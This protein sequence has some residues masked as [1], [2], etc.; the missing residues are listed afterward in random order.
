M[1]T[2]IGGTRRETKEQTDFVKKVG[3]FEAAVIAVNPTVEQFK[4]LLGRELPEDSKASDYLSESRDGN[5]ALRLSF[6]LKEVKT[7]ELF[8]VSFFLEDKERISKDGSKNQYINQTGVCSWAADDDGLATWFKGT[9]DNPKDY[10]IAY[11][12]EEQL[13][14][15][16]RTWLC[17]LDYSKSDTILSLDWKKLMR[18]NV[19]EISSQ[20]DGEWCG[21]VVAMATIATRER[22]GEMKEYQGVYNAAFLPSYAL[23]QFRLVNYNDSKRIS[24]LA[25]K[26]PKELRVHEKFV[27]K[28]AGEYGCKDYYLFS[29]LQDYDPEQNLVASDKVISEDDADF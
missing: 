21:N 19:S 11:V 13:Y 26:K 20:I 9:A 14:E 18:S 4:T 29:E 10:R 27:L 6:W 22:D 25:S 15:F 12:G 8:N 16:M 23:K 7:E 24:D 28:L 3:L 17:H 1:S 5:T 2:G